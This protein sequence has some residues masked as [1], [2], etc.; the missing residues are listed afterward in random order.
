MVGSAS[1]S[2]PAQRRWCCWTSGGQHAALPERPESVT[3][4]PVREVVPD[5]RLQIARCLYQAFAAHDAAALL[6]VLAPGFRGV[7][8]EGMPQDLGGIYDGAETMLR[9]CWVHV[10]A[11]LDLRPVPAEYLPITDDRVVVLGRY[12]GTARGTGRR[13]RRPSRTC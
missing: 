6:T 12:E 7:V 2:V 3:D 1:R 11:L 13:C 4:D 5:D 10:F 8:C 9:D